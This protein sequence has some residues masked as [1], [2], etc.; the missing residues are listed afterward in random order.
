[1]RKECSRIRLSFDLPC[2]CSEVIHFS[3]DVHVFPVQQPL[4][5]CWLL[6]V[7]PISELT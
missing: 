7:Q 4:V 6:L 5:A 2:A 1:M 3:C